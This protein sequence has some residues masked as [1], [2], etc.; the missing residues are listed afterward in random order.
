MKS[1]RAFLNRMLQNLRDAKQSDQV[2]L[3]QTFYQD[4]SW[5]HTFLPH[6]NGVCLYGHPSLPGT[7]QIDASSQGLGGRWGNQVYK[8]SI[9]FGMDNLG[10]VQLKMLNLYLAFGVWA[11]YGREKC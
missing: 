3:D 5:H 7:I 6:F 11:P 4:L 8:L 1:S 10:I 2:V 9:P